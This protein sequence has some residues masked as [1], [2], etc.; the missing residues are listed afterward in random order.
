MLFSVRD[1]RYAKWKMGIARSLDW[2]DERDDNEGTF[3][4][5]LLLS[6]VLTIGGQCFNFWFFGG[7]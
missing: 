5:A 3:R 6:F 1:M 7:V 2:T 4:F